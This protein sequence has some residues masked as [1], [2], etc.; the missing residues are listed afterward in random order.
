MYKVY[1][2]PRKEITDRRTHY[3]GTP[4]M[5]FTKREKEIM[6]PTINKSIFDVVRISPRDTF[7]SFGYRFICSGAKYFLNFT[8]KVKG[9]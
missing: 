5:L 2:A 8:S 6:F 7:H 9:E 3:Y 1:Y 4:D